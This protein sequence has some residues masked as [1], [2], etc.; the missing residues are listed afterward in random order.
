MGFKLPLTNPITETERDEHLL[1]FG[2][3]D[4]VKVLDEAVQIGD[5]ECFGTVLG[6]VDEGGSCV[7][8]DP[9]VRLIL[10]G[11]QER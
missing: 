6:E 4:D 2:D 8:L 1:E 10:H 7:G 9:R 11:L 5:E 3:H